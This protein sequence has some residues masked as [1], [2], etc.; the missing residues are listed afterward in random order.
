HWQRA[1]LNAWKLR[2]KGQTIPWND[3]LIATMALDLDMRVYAKDAH[4]DLMANRIGL[5]LYE[6]GYGGRYTPD[7]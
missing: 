4:F 5:R 3:I 6:P 1:I 2:D 7:D